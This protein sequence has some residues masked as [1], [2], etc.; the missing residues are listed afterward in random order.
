MNRLETTTDMPKPE[1]GGWV[2]VLITIIVG[3]IC[4]AAGLSSSFLVNYKNRRETK[5]ALEKNYEQGFAEGKTAAEKEFYKKSVESKASHG[6]MVRLTIIQDLGRGILEIGED[7]QVATKKQMQVALGRINQYTEI[8]GGRYKYICF[9]ACA[10]VGGGVAV[11]YDEIFG[12]FL[13]VFKGKLPE[14]GQR[15]GIE[16]KNGRDIKVLYF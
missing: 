8:P 1:T 3:L 14:E 5:D 12:Y 6:K 16:I 9:N 7:G 11:A 13:V 15:E 10:K 4:F 2:M